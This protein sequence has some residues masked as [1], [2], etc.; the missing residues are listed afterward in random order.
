MSG[1]PNTALGNC[2]IMY[3][4]LVRALRESGVTDADL[5]IDG[6]DS[7]IFLSLAE[8]TRLGPECEPILNAIREC[9]MD[10]RV[11]GVASVLEEVE[12]CQ[13]RYVA[14]TPPRFVR[15]PRKVMSTI[16]SSVKMLYGNRVDLGHTIAI[17]ELMLNRGVPVLQEFAL[18]LLRHAPKGKIV[19]DSSDYG[20]FYKVKLLKDVAKAVPVTFEARMSF[21][22]AFGV[23]VPTQVCLEY[24]LQRWEFSHDIVSSASFNYEQW[25]SEAPIFTERL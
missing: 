5:L 11:E 2:V 9:G 16:M 3:L 25:R 23:D 21:A 13:C 24:Y 22:A 14:T 8:F 12:W 20:Y 18:A 19:D 4:I 10:P 1:D 15:N 6:D 7:L 17:G